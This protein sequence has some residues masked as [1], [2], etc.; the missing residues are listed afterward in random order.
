MINSGSNINIPPIIKIKK[1][2]N[3]SYR[4]WGAAWLEVTI[5]KI[6]AIIYNPNIKEAIFVINVPP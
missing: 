3:Q 5:E 6:K 4:F 2:I 1:D